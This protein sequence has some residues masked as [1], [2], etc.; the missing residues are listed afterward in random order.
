MRTR[1][2][3][4]LVGSLIGLIAIVPVSQN[5]NVSLILSALSCVGGGAMLGYLA[6][7]ASDVFGAAAHS[8]E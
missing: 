2:L 3:L 1:L 8:E 7:V 6:S 5:F 4:V